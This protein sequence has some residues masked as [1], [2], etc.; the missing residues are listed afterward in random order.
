MVNV[1]KLLCNGSMCLDNRLK[2]QYKK[3]LSYVNVYV[4]LNR[5]VTRTFWLLTMK[6]K[7]T[8][9][10]AAVCLRRARFY[11]KADELGSTYIL[12]TVEFRHAWQPRRGKAKKPSWHHMESSAK[13]A[14]EKKCAR[15]YDSRNCL[16]WYSDHPIFNRWQNPSLHLLKRQP[17]TLLRE[18]WNS[19]LYSSWRN[20]I[21]SFTD[22]N[23]K[24][25]VQLN[26]SQQLRQ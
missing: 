19:F 1:L 11:S 16:L 17:K 7:F 14:D 24:M 26:I 3:M 22:K 13:V 9:L 23:L 21:T 5:F 20:R 8:H 25:R 12:N 6:N 15:P 4:S 18:Q 10:R 2:T